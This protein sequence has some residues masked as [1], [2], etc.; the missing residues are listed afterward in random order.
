MIDPFISPNPLA[1]HINLDSL[2]ADYILLSHGHEDHIADAM[3]LAQK[4]NAIIV[5]NYEIV[6]WFELK[7]H[8]LGHPMN[9]GGK[10]DFGT[11]S[12]KSIN[13]I[14]SSVLPDGSNGGNP[15][16]FLIK[17]KGKCLYYSGDT[18]LNSDM[19]LL[20]EF[21]NIDVAILAIAD[22]FTIGIE[23]ASIAAQFINCNKIIGMHFNTFPYIEIDTKYAVNYFGER[24]QELII[25]EL[26]GNLNI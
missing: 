12:V 2:K 13:A 1:K 11:F 25:M 17:T 9:I 3:Y 24:E 7:G 4:N 18:A 5:S 26:G 6:S 22:N 23:D 21:E 8:K 10:K 14:H 15:G 19:K 20:G 16:G